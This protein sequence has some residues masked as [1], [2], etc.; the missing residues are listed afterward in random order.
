MKKLLLVI[1][2]CF[3]SS[4]AF[5][6]EI[7]GAWLGKLNVGVELR[8][9][10]N[11]SA[12]NDS[13]ISTLDSPD[14]GAFGIP[15]SS[16][17]YINGELNIAV[18]A[19]DGGY[20]GTYNTEKKQFEGL[21]LQGPNKIPLAL[22]KVD[23]VPSIKR[24]QTP[25]LPFP[26]RSENITFLN[27]EAPGVELA[28]TITIP[29][30]KGPFNA[31]V[32]VSGSG[33]QNRNENLL[34][35]EPF[36]V[37]SDYLTRNGIVVLRY[38]DRGVGESKGD[39]NT[40]TSMD[41]ASDASAAVNY[42]VSRTD[43]PIRNIGIA[44]H[45]EGGLIAPITASENNQVDFIVLMAGPGIPGDSILLLQGDLIAKASG[46]SK[47]SI[48]ALHELRREIMEVAK[49]AIDSDVMRNQMITLNK[50]FIANTPKHILDE[51]EMTE[52]D[53]EEGLDVYT[54]EWM[55]FFL[56]Y[57]PRPTLEHT[58]IP[59][60]AINGTT[61]LQVPYKENLEAIEKALIKAGNKNYQV[62][63]LENLNHLF[64]YSVT[65]S[66]MEYG[67]IEE[68]FNLNAMNIIYNWISAQK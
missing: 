5:A 65:G 22:V 47:E 60:L 57:N 20:K 30:G 1:G 58:T 26:Y 53:V 52:D 68:T 16:T 13:L 41:F 19:I 8:V 31:V 17:T 3:I 42:L 66:P 34:N 9:V 46:I 2:I 6:Q 15:S 14:Q 35:H 37:L 12:S 39:F 33:P 54:G 4:I 10:F 18:P 63:A 49:D 7:T 55:Q 44:G 29:E 56:A 51:L 36:L 62:K 11:I 43:I 40:S 45:S 27:N 61:D 38:D 32:L 64:Q 59:V 67:T 50:N 48:K 25:K 21:W 24:P 23:S 28:G